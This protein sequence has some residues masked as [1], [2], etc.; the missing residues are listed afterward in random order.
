VTEMG[1]VRSGKHPR[2]TIIFSDSLRETEMRSTLQREISKLQIETIQLPVGRILGVR[3]I[4]LHDKTPSPSS[5]AGI[6]GFICDCNG[7]FQVRK[8]PP[9][10][11]PFFILASRDGDAQFIAT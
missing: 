3:V 8:T 10:N 6:L 1:R 11:V 5:R 7:L 2:I 4:L 9:N